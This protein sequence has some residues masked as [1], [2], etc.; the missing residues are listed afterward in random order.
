MHNVAVLNAHHIQN[1]VYRNIKCCVQLLRMLHGNF[2]SRL[3][4][5][6]SSMTLIAL[7]ETYV[8][9]NEP[10]EFM[11]CTYRTAQKTSNLNSLSYA[12]V[13]YNYSSKLH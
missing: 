11:I 9:K 12:V 7:N 10:S 8:I 13:D 2:I 6:N 1:L 5:G 3:G 4:G